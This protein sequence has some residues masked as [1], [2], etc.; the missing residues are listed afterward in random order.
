MNNYW[1]LLAGAVVMTLMILLWSLFWG[2]GQSP[3]VAVLLVAA[4]WAISSYLMIK[5]PGRI[6]VADPEEHLSVKDVEHAVSGLL[7]HM[8]GHLADIISDM[9]GD[10]GQIQQLVG[11]AVSTLQSSFS[12]LNDRSIKQ[13]QMVNEMINR[14]SA[15]IDDEAV[16]SF[17]RF[18]SETDEVLKLFIDYVASTSA[19]S[20]SMVERIDEMVQQMN[21]ANNLLS[22]VKVIAD[23]T[24]LLALNAAIEAARA[25]EAGRGFAVVADEVRNL[26]KRSN[27]FNEEIR[28]VIKV[29][30]ENIGGARETIEKL[31]SQD[32]DFAV[33]SKARVKEMTADLNELNDSIESTLGQISQTTNEIDAMVIDAIRSLQF[34]DIVRQ[35]TDYSGHHL[36]RIQGLLTDIHAG[37]TTLRNAEDVDP[38]GFIQELLA[39]QTRLDIFMVDSRRSGEKPVKQA[40]MSEGEIELF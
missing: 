2:E 37:L 32:L 15:G 28:S 1:K 5:G 10:L 12:G 34:E 7:G 20:M 8:D 3:A 30:I 38:T 22:D 9:R 35:L 4:A 27:R 19:N 17:K 13:Q 18:A 6:Q 26:S 33:H 25:G 23:Q 14:M 24:N 11:D 29:S 21:S 39:L 40:S 16:T 36:D 31:A